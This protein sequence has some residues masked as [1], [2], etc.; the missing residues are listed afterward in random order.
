MYIPRNILYYYYN[1]SPKNIG[2]KIFTNC[3]HD[4]Q[5]NSQIY[6]TAQEYKIKTL[7]YTIMIICNI[8]RDGRNMHFSRRA[9]R[10]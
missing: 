1:I 4:R 2:D 8:V 6:Y 5:M 9:N 7:K 10:V 3:E